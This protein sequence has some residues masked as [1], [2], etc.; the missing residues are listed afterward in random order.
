M[1]NLCDWL[2]RMEST[3]PNNQAGNVI[4]LRNTILPDSNIV[5]FLLRKKHNIRIQIRINIRNSGFEYCGKRNNRIC[6]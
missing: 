1:I 2:L 5:F 4:E 6:A 3:H